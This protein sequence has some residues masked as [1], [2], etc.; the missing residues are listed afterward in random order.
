MLIMASPHLEK[1]LEEVVAATRAQKTFHQDVKEA[2]NEIRVNKSSFSLFERPLV[3]KDQYMDK[4]QTH[5]SVY[6]RDSDVLVGFL[7]DTDA[8]FIFKTNCHSFPVTLKAGEF[9]LA[10][11]GEGIIPM[12]RLAFHDAWIEKLQGS[13]RRICALLDNDERRELCH[14]SLYPLGAEY[15]T[16]SGMISKRLPS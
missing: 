15:S 4:S 12:I 13:V 9:Q 14:L 5:T 7:A 2:L 3:D 6:F 10:W 16:S 11:K 8:T 1:V